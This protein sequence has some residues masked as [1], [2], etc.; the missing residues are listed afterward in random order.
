[1]LQN[2]NGYMPYSKDLYGCHGELLDKRRARNP[3]FRFHPYYT[4][5]P[6]LTKLLDWCPEAHDGGMMAVYSGTLPWDNL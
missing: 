6:E 4:S 2:K 3:F 1:M 5:A